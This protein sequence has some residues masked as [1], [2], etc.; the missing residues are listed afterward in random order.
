M[1]EYN[2]NLKERVRVMEAIVRVISGA[3]ER[4]PPY[5]PFPQKGGNGL[6]LRPRIMIKTS[7]TYD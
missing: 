3:L 2:R 4:N 1:I 6:S 7:V 5:P